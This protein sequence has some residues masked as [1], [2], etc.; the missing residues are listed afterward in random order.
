MRQDGAVGGC[1]RRSAE[2]GN[3]NASSGRVR[4]A[5]RRNVSE[6]E[7][8]EGGGA[9]GPADA[10]RVT[11]A[12]KTERGAVCEGKTGWG[13]SQSRKEGGISAWAAKEKKSGQGRS[14]AR[15]ASG[16]RARHAERAIDGCRNNSTNT[17]NTKRCE[18]W[19]SGGGEPGA[20]EPGSQRCVRCGGR[21]GREAN[22]VGESQ[23]PAVFKGEEAGLGVR[24]WV[25]CLNEWAAA[26]LYT[27]PNPNHAPETTRQ[28]RTPRPPSAAPPCIAMSLHPRRGTQA[29]SRSMHH[30]IIQ[31]HFSGVRREE[32]LPRWGT[33]PPPWMGERPDACR[34]PCTASSSHRRASGSC[35]NMCS[36]FL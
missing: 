14:I 19:R 31:E 28:M 35:L 34:Q 15:H 21:K 2:C 10:A 4:S 26:S 5:P 29:L 18:F 16:W 24:G 36:K 9:G 12:T 33:L 22:W 1:A 11:D 6:S 27:S 8:G 7:L 32:A 13:I 3:A 25:C 23:G 30:Y 20:R 17:H